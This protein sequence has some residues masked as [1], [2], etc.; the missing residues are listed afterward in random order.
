MDE[1]IAYYRANGG[2]KFIG[3]FLTL[4]G[5][6]LADQGNYKQ[7]IS[8]YKRFQRVARLDLQAMATRNHV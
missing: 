8:V 2:N 7:A 3:P 5:E 4:L 1:A 6:I